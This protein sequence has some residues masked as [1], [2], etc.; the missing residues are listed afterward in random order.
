MIQIWW[1][2][3]ATNDTK[4]GEGKVSIIKIVFE[5]MPSELESVWEQ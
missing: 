1:D 4:I 2:K 3:R 5:I